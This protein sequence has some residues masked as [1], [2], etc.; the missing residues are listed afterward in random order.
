MKLKLIIPWMMLSFWVFA[1]EASIMPQTQGDVS[2]IGGGVGS[3]ERERLQAIGTDYN[4]RLIFSTQG[5]G[6][7]LSGVNVTIKDAGGKIV[8]ETVT[9]GPMLFVKLKP[10]RY[11]V[12]VDYQARLMH[13]TVTVNDSTRAPLAFAWPERR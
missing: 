7:Y 3:D 2:F 6:D 5:S 13:K 11:G 9:D 1:Q 8:L 12:S 10:G 4:L